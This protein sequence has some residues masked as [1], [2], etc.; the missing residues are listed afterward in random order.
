MSTDRER[1]DL[2]ATLHQHR[3]LLR[4]TLRDLDEAQ[5][6]ST[7]SV[8]EL[9]LAALIKHVADT[10]AGWI[11]FAR[12]GTMPGTESWRG[13]DTRFLLGEEHTLP[14]LLAHYDAVAADTDAFIAEADLD[15]EHPL[16]EAP[17][18]PPGTSWTVRRVLWHVLA[19]TSQ[20]AGHA[21]I[22]RESIDGAK[23]MG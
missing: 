13:E 18:F 19:E 5:A 6:R 21:D 4:G 20:H 7:P 14:V 12:T 15:S 8:S 10:E 11:A 22:I 1:H 17:W 9:S 2:A 3:G 23:S 16:P